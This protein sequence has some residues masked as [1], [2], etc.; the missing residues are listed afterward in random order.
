MGM[1]KGRY[2]PKS[3]E[4]EKREINELLKKRVLADRLGK[5]IDKGLQKPLE[6]INKNRYLYS[7]SSCSGHDGYPYITVVFKD[8]ETTKNYLRKLKK[9]RYK[10][11]LERLD[12]MM[13]LSISFP[14]IP[15]YKPR[16]RAYGYF[17][18]IFKDAR[19]ANSFKKVLEKRKYKIEKK[20]SRYYIEVP[21]YDFHL[22]DKRKSCKVMFKKLI[23]AQRWKR[24]I[25]NMQRKSLYSIWRIKY[26]IDNELVYIVDLPLP[27]NEDAKPA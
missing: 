3:F 24:D 5:G 2:K 26:A 18:G 22:P 23:F 21:I 27:P 25:E 13:A 16:T 11:E 1:F 9:T 6:K 7:S 20:K 12:K 14:T 4:T 15:M 17:E 8:A 10:L 19:S